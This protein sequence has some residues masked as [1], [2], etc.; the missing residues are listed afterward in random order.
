VIST[1]V[2]TNK[3]MVRKT[4]ILSMAA[5]FMQAISAITLVFLALGIF[6]LGNR[7]AV[8]TTE[9]V[10]EPLSFAAVSV[11]GAYI[12]WRSLRKLAQVG[13]ANLSEVS[14]PASDHHHHASHDHHHHESEDHAHTHR[15]NADGVCGCGHKHGPS[16]TDVAHAES[17]WQM[18]GLVV[19]IGMRPCSGAL[20]VLIAAHLKGLTLIGVLAVFAMAVGTGLTVASLATGVHLVRLPF[21]YWGQK[22]GARGWIARFLPYAGAWIA[23]LGGLL[24]VTLGGL[25]V[26]DALQAPVHPFAR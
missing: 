10:L 11:L 18:L 25:L 23:L 24:L 13:R 12:V 9:Q 22:A 19:S 1:Y 26:W 4:Y 16:I 8:Q 5:A 7:W 14:A 15:H 20:I 17:M 3:V 6:E 2:L 21:A